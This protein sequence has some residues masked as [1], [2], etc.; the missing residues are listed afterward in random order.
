MNATPQEFLNQSVP[1]Y[2]NRKFVLLPV[3]ILTAAILWGIICSIS[4]WCDY[5]SCLADD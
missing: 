1:F 5:G 2:K 3:P 4:I